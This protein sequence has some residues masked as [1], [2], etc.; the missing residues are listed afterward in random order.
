VSGNRSRL[1]F[2]VRAPGRSAWQPLL[3]TMGALDQCA[4]LLLGWADDALLELASVALGRSPSASGSKSGGRSI[5]AYLHGEVDLQRDISQ[6]IVHSDHRQVSSA[7]P[8]ASVRALCKTMG[9]EL[10]WMSDDRHRRNTLASYRRS[11]FGNMSATEV[12]QALVDPLAMPRY[13]QLRQRSANQEA[14][15]KPRMTMDAARLEVTALPKPLVNGAPS[16][17][18]PQM[19]TA[20]GSRRG[21]SDIMAPFD[22]AS[23]CAVDR[24]PGGSPVMVKQAPIPRARSMG[25]SALPEHAKDQLRLQ[26]QAQLSADAPKRLVNGTPGFTEIAAGPSYRAPSRRGGSRK[27][28]RP[29]SAGIRR[30]ASQSRAKAVAP[31]GQTA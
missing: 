22:V 30:P 6:I 24:M 17:V 14:V 8:E 19:N 9:W 23:P 5:S 25:V 2:P 18:V 4:H 21:Q 1:S 15:A 29:A 10:V 13:D 20:A 11:R 7:Y 31:W 12:E 26:L 27:K 3:W 28:T 16:L